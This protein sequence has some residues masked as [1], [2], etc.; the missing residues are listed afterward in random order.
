MSTTRQHSL[1]KAFIR[2]VWACFLV[3]LPVTSFPYFPPAIGGETLVRPL[4]I[5]PLIILILFVVLPR[6]FSR[7]V[8][9][10]FISL[11]P[12][13]LVATASSL[14]SLLRGIE[15]ALG[16]SVT[17]RI[18]RGMFTLA[19]GCATYL[20]L[21]LLPEEPSDLNYS[22]KWI[23]AGCAMALFWSSLQVIYI[24]HFN[25]TWFNFLSRIQEHISI[26][27]LLTDR[28]SGLTYEPHWFADQMI[29]LLVP[30]TLAAV[31]S[32]HTIFRW[33]WRWL[34]IEHLLLGW[35]ILVLPFT[36]SRSGLLNLVLLAALSAFFFHIRSKPIRRSA[37][38]HHERWSSIPMVRVALVLLVV[39]LPVYLAGTRN[40]F[41]SRLWGYWFRDDATLSG[42]ISS[43]GFDARAAYSQAAFN[44]FAKYPFLGV[45][46]G[47][48]GFYL[49]EMLPYRPI[50]YIPEVLRVI[51]PEFGRDRLV[52]SKN[53][54]LRLLAETGIVGAVAFLVFGIAN[55]GNAVWLWLA[56][57]EEPR[58]WGGVSMIGLV[59]F[60]LSAFTFD[61]F[62]IPNM[63]VVFGMIS[64]A[65][66]VFKKPTHMLPVPAAFSS[67]SPDP[68]RLG[69]STASEMDS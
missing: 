15:P 62:V 35:A 32:G 33:R 14:L 34:T 61:S 17:A 10:T 64:A 18:F 58:Y 30:G 1:S 41:F 52:T 12:F 54:Y 36:F 63:W 66:Y 13:M 31:L 60:A 23:Y 3:T 44:T 42:Y 57:P 67:K 48:Y 27:R 16:I 26:R 56:T 47:N 28:I 8:P 19:I 24:I 29:L 2:V 65:T 50:A 25:P 37:P 7:P 59:A 55:L 69:Q 40:T 49:E 6:L 21:S 43:L 53:F 68:H 9:R 22:L 39:S 20:T 46:L 5:Y 11:L 38:K 4:T 51:T 45:G